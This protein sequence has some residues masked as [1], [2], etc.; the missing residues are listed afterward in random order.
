MA[1]L[2]VHEQDCRRLLG[3]PFREVHLFLDEFHAEE[4][5]THRRH[6]H[7]REGLAEV[8]DRWGE[9]AAQAARLHII[10]DC[11]WVPPARAY[12][13]GTVDELGIRPGDDFTSARS[14]LEG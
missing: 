2:T 14:A 13:S 11:G 6:R 8:R 3:R 12:E 7:H 4:G 9:L 5:P 1:L 10:R